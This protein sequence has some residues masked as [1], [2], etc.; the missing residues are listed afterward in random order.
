LHSESKMLKVVEVSPV[1]EKKFRNY[2][3]SP[4]QDRV[5]NTYYLNH[6]KQTVEYVLNKKMQM[7]PLNKYQMNLWEVM[8]KLNEV[9]DD[10]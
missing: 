8:G 6:T 5:S 9:I 1:P 10:R 4:W 7:Q 3:D 2:I